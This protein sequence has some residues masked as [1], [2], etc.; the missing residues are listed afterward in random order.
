MG[1]D[2]ASA[3]AAIGRALWRHARDLTID[4]DRDGRV[5]DA[6]P[7][8][9][10]WLGGT[11]VLLDAVHPHDATRLVALL[12]GEPPAHPEFRFAS[13]P[14]E[15]GWRIVEVTSTTPTARGAVIVGR[16]VTRERQARA[17]LDAHREV[18]RLIAAA[19][20]LPAVLDALA[21]SVEAA[22]AGARVVVLVARDDDLEL[23]AGPSLR[24]DASAGF[25][26]LRGSA[27]PGVFPASGALSGRIA[28]VAAEHGL[29][30]GWAAPVHDGD[31]ALGVLVLLP[32]AKR[33]PSAD[34][35]AA[36]E[37]G[38]PLAHVAIAAHR[39]R[40]EHARSAG[41]DALTGVCGRQ[42]FVAELAQLGRRTRD[43]LGVLVVQVDGLAAVNAKVG[44]VA[45]DTLLQVLATRLAGAVRGRDVV[46]RVSGTRFA[47]ASTA[48]GP[49][50]TLAELAARVETVLA[51]AVTVGGAEVAVSVRLASATHRG[52]LGEP[53]ALLLEAE[54]ALRAG[55]LLR[56]AGPTGER[57][58]E[59]RSGAAPSDR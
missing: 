12:T 47:V 59:R 52:R 44:G 58:R 10:A 27:A 6:S 50:T 49:S 57:R 42:A 7:A 43:A 45:G 51:E 4:A 17:T 30:F 55:R 15:S 11:E 35:Q 25:A 2:D 46:G 14:P 8:A 24:A 34:E 56:D 40:A 36:L 48:L 39:L 54:E 37:A 1:A 16:E 53:D 13:L 26:R 41:H 9:R 33:F 5:H 22:S 21:R 29:G 23:A 20:P 18:L 3:N 28:E 32:G 31:D 38:V 19:E